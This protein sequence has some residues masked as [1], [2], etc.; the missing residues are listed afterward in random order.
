MRRGH[1]AQN[2]AVLRQL[3]LTLLRRETTA[4]V[5]IKA[6]RLMCGWNAAYLLKVLTG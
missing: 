1:A 6:K 4:K 5:G 2:L 3:A